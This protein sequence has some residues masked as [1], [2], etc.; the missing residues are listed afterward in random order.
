M[1]ASVPRCRA[2]R[3]RESLWRPP[4]SRDFVRRLRTSSIDILKIDKAFVDPISKGPAGTAIA[5]AI[6]GMARAMELEVVAEGIES[7]EQ[8][9]QLLSLDAASGRVTT[10]P[11]Q[12]PTKH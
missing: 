2:P 6:V 8:V 5:Q 4:A 7:S 10:S 11:D 12:P 3:V 1:A 9:E